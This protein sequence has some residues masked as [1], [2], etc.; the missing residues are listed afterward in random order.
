M[1]KIIIHP[2]F[3]DIIQNKTYLILIDP[4]I[5]ENNGYLRS[6]PFIER[7]SGY[8]L[9]TL[10]T[11]E[12]GQN[13][14]FPLNICHNNLSYKHPLDSQDEHNFLG[15]A[16]N[17]ELDANTNYVQRMID[18]PAPRIFIT[19]NH[20]FVA[21][22]WSEAYLPLTQRSAFPPVSFLTELGVLLKRD[23]LD[24]YILPETKNLA[25][26]EL[27][28]LYHKI[29]GNKVSNLPHLFD[30]YSGMTSILPIWDWALMLIELKKQNVVADKPT[31]IFNA[32]RP[33]IEQNRHV[34]QVSEIIYE[35]LESVKFK[36]ETLRNERQKLLRSD[37]SRL[38]GIIQS[39]EDPTFQRLI[40][41]Q[42]ERVQW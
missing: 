30:Y 9:K 38:E 36:A 32:L 15:I 18:F 22:G 4:H 14:K 1:N 27:A 25:F 39:N 42:M 21:S 17:A 10:M 19:D 35:L 28:F 2:L 16:V 7:L 26:I 29:T 5:K 13:C 41:K 40:R 23:N 6:V 33:W 37:R 31:F 12:A 11:W 34:K 20:D 3:S 24:T 8:T